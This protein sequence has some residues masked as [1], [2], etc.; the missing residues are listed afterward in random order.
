LDVK[1]FVA[2]NTQWKSWCTPRII[3]FTKAS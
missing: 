2:S 1:N 3:C